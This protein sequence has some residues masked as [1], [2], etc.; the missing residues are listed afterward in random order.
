MAKQPPKSQGSGQPEFVWTGA[1]VKTA[2]RRAVNRTMVALGARTSSGAKQRV[3][4]L[5]GTLSRSIHEAPPDYATQSA[6][7]HEAAKTTDLAGSA[8]AKLPVWDDKGEAALEVGS[9][10]PYA[11]VEEARHPFLAPALDEAMAGA[12]ETFRQAFA[13]EGLG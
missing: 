6:G 5:T 7:D 13:E 11:C 4:R 8:T 2:G 9:Y 12:E 1:E 3:H 10:L